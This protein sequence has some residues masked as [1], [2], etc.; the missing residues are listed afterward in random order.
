MEEG[1][2]GGW[3]FGVVVNPGTTGIKRVQ[4]RGTTV[5]EP[6]EEAGGVELEKLMVVD[7]VEAA[8][9][10]LADKQRKEAVNEGFVGGWVEVQLG[11]KKAAEFAASAEAE[12]LGQAR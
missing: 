4:G 9:Q 1:V 8:E 2:D 6:P 3:C 10:A 11:S 7:W 12:A 5:A